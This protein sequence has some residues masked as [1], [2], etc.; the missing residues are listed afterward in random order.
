MHQ[1]NTLIIYS[2]IA[3]ALWAQRQPASA[4]L[5]SR[6]ALGRK[7]VT[8]LLLAVLAVTVYLGLRGELGLMATT[9][10]RCVEG[11]SLAHFLP[12]FLEGVAV[13]FLWTRLRAAVGPV[14]SLLIPCLLFA[15]AHVPRAIEE[16][17]SVATI[18]AFFV[19]NTMLPLAILATVAR[20]RDVVWVGVVHWFMDVAIRAFE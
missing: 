14:P 15:A 8:G 16:R 3:V 4:V 5:L 19:F 1:G 17:Q 18:A 2:P 20:S 6:T 9:A 13:A 12:V 7:L 11:R 10:A